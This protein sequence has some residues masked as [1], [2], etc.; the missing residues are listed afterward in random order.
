MVTILKHGSTKKSIEQ[1]LARLNKRKR[2]KG[3]D[4]YKYCGILTISRDALKIQ[5]EMRNEWD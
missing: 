1:L 3:V 2:I 5:K 4:A